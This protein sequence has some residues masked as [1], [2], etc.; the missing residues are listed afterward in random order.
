ML[1]VPVLGQ[2]GTWPVRHDHLRK[3]GA[4]TLRV[5]ADSIVF[6]E[7]DK[8]GRPTPH[9]R[10]W[11]YSEIQ[12]LVLGNKTLWLVTYEDQKWELGRDREYRFD[13]VPAAMVTELY[14][15]W[16]EKLDARFVA[17]LADTTE[18][19]EWSLPVKLAEGRAGSQGE[20]SVSAGHV[21]YRTARE[22]ESRTWRLADIVNV[23][24]SGL[25][26]LTIAT[27]EKDFRFQLKEALPEERYN[28][29]WRRVNRSNGLQ[30]LTTE[31][32]R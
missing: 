22:G 18:K 25:F 29:L 3:F 13:Q 10:E 4:G 30:I 28:A 6:E 9:S 20:L 23:S 17:A 2:Q 12:K 24:S 15:A 16:R 14:A 27:H 21:V 7:K 19:A 5:S 32:T 8:K 11:K 26:D 1:A 31:M